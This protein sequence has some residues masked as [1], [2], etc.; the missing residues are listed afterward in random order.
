MDPIG[1]GFFT[2]FTIVAALGVLGTVAWWAFLKFIAKPFQRA[3][4]RSRFDA[5]AEGAI[6]REHTRWL[7]KR[8]RRVV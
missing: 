7:A 4:P 2:P 8:D 5:T 6:S 1:G 3:D